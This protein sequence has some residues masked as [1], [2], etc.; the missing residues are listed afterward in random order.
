MLG[1]RFFVYTVYITGES[2]TNN[3]LSQICLESIVN[4]TKHK[5]CPSSL[6]T[7]E[8]FSWKNEIVYRKSTTQTSQTN[9]N[10]H[11]T[12]TVELTTNNLLSLQ[13]LFKP[14]DKNQT[15][16]NFKIYN[17]SDDIYLLMIS[18]S[19]I[20]FFV[21]LI[22]PL[23]FVKTNKRFRKF[24]KLNED[25]ETTNKLAITNETNAIKSSKVSFKCC[26][27]IKFIYF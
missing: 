2:S 27:L 15:D 16:S 17:Y 1:L 10:N 21:S 13:A 6:M 26:K 19:L 5:L 14:L 8:F 4:S 9:K 7:N 12:Q 18:V 11:L 25:I 24:T 23:A 20:N 3:V 22:I